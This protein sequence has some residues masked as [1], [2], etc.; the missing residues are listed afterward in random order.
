MYLY[1]AEHTT[2][3]KGNLSFHL[4]LG[5]CNWKTWLIFNLITW[6]DFRK[7]TSLEYLF[8]QYTSLLRPVS[9]GSASL[10]WTVSATGVS[11]FGF[12]SLSPLI[13][14]RSFMLS[15]LFRVCAKDRAFQGHALWVVPGNSKI[16]PELPF[17]GSFLTKSHIYAEKDFV[18]KCV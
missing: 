2:L 5:L 6:S 18:S 11:W 3:I 10:S 14:S 9:W 13:V 15:S 8:K 16:K 12:S 4:D 7:S 17:K 1:T